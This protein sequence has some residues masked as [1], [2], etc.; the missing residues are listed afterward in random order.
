SDD[1][2]V[3]LIDE[4]RTEPGIQMARVAEIAHS[5]LEE[6]LLNV[7]GTDQHQRQEYLALMV[8]LQTAAVQEFERRRAKITTPDGQAALDFLV[9]QDGESLKSLV[10][11]ATRGLRWHPEHHSERDATEEISAEAHVELTTRLG[12]IMNASDPLRERMR[13]CLSGML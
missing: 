8:L 5:M 12:P 13:A 9:R 3:R 4:L 10:R 7:L 11:H 2:L 1:D 6:F